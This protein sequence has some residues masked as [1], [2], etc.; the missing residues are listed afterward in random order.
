MNGDQ[1][2][3]FVTRY[4]NNIWILCFKCLVKIFT[5]VKGI[6]RKEVL[7][8]W[9]HGC[10]NVG[11]HKVSMAEEQTQKIKGDRIMYHIETYAKKERD[12]MDAGGI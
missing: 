12:D 10:T 7:K 4:L 9:A 3:L 8:Y 6:R 1:Y 5:G 11:P 2:D